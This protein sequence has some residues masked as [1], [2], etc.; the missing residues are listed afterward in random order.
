MWGMVIYWWRFRTAGSEEVLECS[1]IIQSSSWRFFAVSR[2]HFF[3]FLTGLMS[4]APLWGKARNCY[5]LQRSHALLTLSVSK[6]HRSYLCNSL[7]F[8][9]GCTVPCRSASPTI[10]L[11]LHSQRQRPSQV[12]TI[13]SLIIST[14]VNVSH[15]LEKMSNDNLFSNHVRF[16][17]W[18]FIE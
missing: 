5:C 7:I 15:S 9:A 11:Q 8:N 14:N 13:T 12:T 3:L 17:I 10:G 1:C 2:H 6:W 16:T 18:S 4:F